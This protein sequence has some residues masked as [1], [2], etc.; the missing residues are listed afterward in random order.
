MCIPYNCDGHGN[1]PGHDS[2]LVIRTA[3]SQRPP[4]DAWLTG[5]LGGGSSD[6]LGL[7]RARQRRVTGT[8]LGATAKFVLLTAQSQRPLSAVC[9]KLPYQ[10]GTTIPRDSDY[11]DMRV[12][13]DSST[14]VRCARQTPK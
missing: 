2:Q 7:P 10:L 12:P 11:P 14:H 5:Q 3:Q 4:L 13:S 9:H 1:S 8:I 6:G